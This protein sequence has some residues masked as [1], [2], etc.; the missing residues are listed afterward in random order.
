LK[1]GGRLAVIAFHSLEDREVKQSFRELGRHGFR[2]VTRKPVR[3]TDAESAHNPR[4]R[5][6]RLR[7]LE[8][9]A[10]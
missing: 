9:E 2:V 3:P 8:K 5:S 6:A 10:A 1:D 4:A 7:V